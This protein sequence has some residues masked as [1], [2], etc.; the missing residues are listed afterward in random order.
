MN[1]SLFSKNVEKHFCNLNC[2]KT[3]N[4][5]KIYRNIYWKNLS[6]I[7]YRLPISL[8]EI[9]IYRLSV[10]PRAFL[11]LSIIVIALVQKDLSCPSLLLNYDLKNYPQ[12]HLHY[13]LMH[14]TSLQ[15]SPPRV[16]TQT[17]EL[18]ARTKLLQQWLVGL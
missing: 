2:K 18:R 13:F 12:P 7:I 9:Q 6:A 4:T 1:R 10:L 16:S 5:F 15:C 8:R 14:P 11:K 3:S 17:T